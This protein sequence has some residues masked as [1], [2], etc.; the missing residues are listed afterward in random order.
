MNRLC[1]LLLVLLV[2]ILST[3]CQ[4]GDDPAATTPPST[5]ADAADVVVAGGGNETG[6]AG[7]AGDTEHAG[8]EVAAGLGSSQ[9]NESTAVAAGEPAM[10]DQAV[11]ADVAFEGWVAGDYYE[12]DQV[13]GKWVR[14]YSAITGEIETPSLPSYDCWGGCY[15]PVLAKTCPMPQASALQVVR[16]AGRAVDS[17]FG[18]DVCVRDGH[19]VPT[20]RMAEGDPSDWVHFRGTYNERD[21]YNRESTILATVTSVLS[22]SPDYFSETVRLN[23]SSSSSWSPTGR[24]P[25]KGMRFEVFA[26][27]EDPVA[28]GRPFAL[29]EAAFIIWDR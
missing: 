20:G 9:A 13:V 2:T 27:L 18:V 12:G 7:D 5:P 17:G 10:N 25:E 28:P 8:E 29:F 23:D 1:G 15:F 4:P 6:S 24:S 21:L 19:M 3:A 26:R 11:N 22:G 16:I 14:V